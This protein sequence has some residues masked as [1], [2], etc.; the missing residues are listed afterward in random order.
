MTFMERLTEAASTSDRAFA[1]AQ[2]ILQVQRDILKAL[3]QRN[4]SERT[5]FVR[6]PFVIT[7]DGTGKG[8]A[9]VN[10]PAGLEL[11][12][13]G[14]AGQGGTSG[15]YIAFYL[16]VEDGTALLG[17]DITGT[18]FSGNFGEGDRTLGQR[19]LLVVCAGQTAGAQIAGAVTARAV[20]PAP[21]PRETDWSGEA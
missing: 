2:E 9:S 11:H 19:N 10:L 6:V 15:G 16:G 14:Y 8:T 21:E 3:E 5:Q 17:M 13:I 4:D 12:M 20:A 18:V 1:L 7:C